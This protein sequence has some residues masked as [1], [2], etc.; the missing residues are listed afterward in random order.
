MAKGTIFKRY[1]MLSD[2]DQ[3]AF[4]RWLEANA[5]M[6]LILAAGIVA[7]ALAGANST[8]PRDPMVADGSK[9]AGSV[10]LERGS[11]Q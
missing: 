10:A 11:K 2:E 5:F 3:R 1:K 7:M 6:G 9:A 4:D 8:A